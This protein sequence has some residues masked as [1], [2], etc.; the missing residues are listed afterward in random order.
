[1]MVM[2]NATRNNYRHHLMF[3]F[4]K[5]VVRQEEKLNTLKLIKQ[6]ITK[7]NHVYFIIQFL[8]DVVV[9]FVNVMWSSS[10]SIHPYLGS[11]SSPL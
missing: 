10:T 6:T 1:M 4:N 5:S 9:C 3:R 8:F 7:E 11:P 2:A